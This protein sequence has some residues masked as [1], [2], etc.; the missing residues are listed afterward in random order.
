[1]STGSKYKCIS[2]HRLPPIKGTWIQVGPLN[3]IRSTWV[4]EEVVFGIATKGKQKGKRVPIKR[5]FHEMS[6]KCIEETYDTIPQIKARI[7]ALKR[8]YIGAGLAVY[9]DPV[10]IVK[11]KPIIYMVFAW[12]PGQQGRI[13]SSRAIHLKAMPL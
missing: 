3:N 1:M 12:K 5:F 10:N 4:S 2:I 11:E 7:A 9:V 13:V 6:F 8:S